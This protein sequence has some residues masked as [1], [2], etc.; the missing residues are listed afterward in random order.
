[1]VNGGHDG[2]G[3]SV[4]RFGKIEYGIVATLVT[5][6]LGFAGENRYSHGVILERIHDLEARSWTKADDNNHMATYAE[7]NGH[8]IVLHEKAP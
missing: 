5:A 6:C 4:V 2:K 1:M 7:K 3:R 8:E